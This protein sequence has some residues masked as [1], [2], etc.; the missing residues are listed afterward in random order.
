VFQWTVVLLKRWSDGW[1]T[2]WQGELYRELPTRR[3][4][5]T[6]GLRVQGRE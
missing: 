1:T 5:G 3:D 2:P 4:S 6:M